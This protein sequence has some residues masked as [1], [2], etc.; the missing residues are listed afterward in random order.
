MKKFVLLFA[1]LF[2]IS[3]VKVNASNVTANNIAKKATTVQ[4]QN[5]GIALSGV[6]ANFVNQKAPVRAKKQK[7]T[8]QKNKAQKVQQRK[9]RKE[10]REAKKAENQ[11]DH[12]AKRA[13]KKNKNKK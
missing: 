7:A 3:L 4:T 11:K 5:Q 8:N 10:D 1:M 13:T 9:K 6:V 2:A 12:K